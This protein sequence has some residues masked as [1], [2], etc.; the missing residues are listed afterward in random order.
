MEERRK[1]VT[2][3]F[4]DVVGS[5]ALGERVDAE[6]LHWALQRWFDRMGEAVERHG[7]T[8]EDYR[9]DG[10]MA[11]FGIPVAHEDDALRAARAALDMREASREVGTP[12]GVQ[13][14]IRIGLNT[15]EA[16]TGS[17]TDG[18]SFTTSDAVNVAARLEQAAPAGE[19][20]LGA[21]HLS[22]GRARGRGRGDRAR[23]TVKGRRAAI[24]AFRLLGVAATAPTRPQRAAAPMVDRDD[25]WARIVAA[26]ERASGAR[27]C[28]LCAVVGSPGV[29]KSRLVAE[30]AETFSDRAT[31]ASGRCL[32]YGET[33]TWWPLD[34]GAG[35]SGLLAGLD[36]DEHPAIP[37]A[38]ELLDPKGDPV[39][40]DEAQ[41]AL[42]VVIERLARRQ[43]LVLTVDDL[44]WADAALLDLLDHLAEAVQ[45]APLL[46]LGTARPELLR[47][48]SRL[49][50]EV[51]PVGPAARRARG[52]APA[53][54]RG[55]DADRHRDPQPHPRGRRGQSAVRRRAGRDGR[56]RRRGADR[57]RAAADDPGAAGG[58]AGPAGSRTSARC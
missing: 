23:L 3:V 27:A 58:A 10:V 54:P 30:L 4:A 56:G 41:W 7:G 34:G 15:G 42:R 47:R 45:D 36:G 38:V 8:I 53:P 25:E 46:V 33:L 11:V 52:R 37:R 5:T 16:T 24:D 28:E 12:R 35:A 9:G 14:R 50:R 48:T 21:R 22:P 17:R 39:A 26:F 49:A 31:V 55:R 32:P 29:G 2:V 57:G 20:L 43:P 51:G 1:V 6:T 18:G 44:Q 13:L 40:P 19:I